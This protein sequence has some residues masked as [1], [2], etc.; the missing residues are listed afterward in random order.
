[1]H[2]IFNLENYKEYLISYYFYNC[3]NNENKKSERK[4][5]L[6]QGYSDEYLQEIIDNTQE[7]ILGLI[8]NCDNSSIIIDLAQDAE[9]IFTNCTGGYHPDVLMTIDEIDKRI[10]ISKHLLKVFLGKNFM[11]YLDEEETEY[12]DEDDEFIIG[13]SYFHP[14]LNITGDFLKKREELKQEKQIKLVKVIKKVSKN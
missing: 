1:M 7:F 3:D 8:D 9:P 13:C 6:E 2:N 11:I 4:R 10:K 14:K 5:I 12:F